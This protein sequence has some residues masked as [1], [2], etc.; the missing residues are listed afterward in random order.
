MKIL[1]KILKVLGILIIL[2]LVAAVVLIKSIK[3][4]GNPQYDGEISLTGLSGEVEVIRDERGVPH[5]YAENEKD[6]YTT[7]GYVMAQERLWQM[8]LIRRATTGRLS[9]I[10]GSDY[11]ETDLFLRSLKM[12]KK[13]EMVLESIDPDIYDALNWFSE[14]V[15]QYIEDAGKNLPTEF[16][17]LRYVPEPWSA[18]YVGNI[19]GYMGWDLA[20]G[21]LSGDIFTHKLIQKIGEDAA[22]QLIPYFDYT[23]DPVYPEF[24]PDMEFLEET[25]AMIKAMDLTADLGLTSFTGS[26]NWAVSGDHSETGLPLFSNDMHLGLSSPGIWMQMHQ[27]IPGKLNVTGVLV[28]GSPFIIAGHNDDIAWGMTNLMVDDIDLYKE[29]VNE[30]GTAYLLDGEWIDIKVEKEVVSTGKENIERE[31][32]YTHRGPIVSGFRNISDAELSMKWVGYDPS[33]E[34]RSVYLLNRASSWDEFNEALTS[35]NAIS[36]NIVYV[37]V[38]GN[39]GLHSAGGIAIR[40]RHGGLIMR[41]DTSLYDWKAYVD[42]YSL[43]YTYNPESGRV[44]SSNNKT[45]TDEYPY[46][47]GTY[48]S[49]PYRINRVRQMLNEKEMFSVEDF[50]RMI[51]DRKSDFAATL[52]PM[53]NVALEDI[54]LAGIDKEVADALS[55]WDYIMSPDIFCPTFFE[56]YYKI[57]TD[58]L[59]EDDMG[60]LYGEF[61]GPVKKYYLLMIMQGEHSLYIDNI[62]TESVEDLESIMISS[63][64]NTIN[65]LS[66]KYGGD[67]SKWIWGDLHAFIAEHPLASVKLIDRLFKLN[68]GPYKVGGSSHTVS[69]YSYSGEF[70]IDHGA[71]ERHIYNPADWDESFTVIPTGISGVPSSE[72]YSSQTE[73]YCNDGFYKDHFSRE[74]VDNAATY[75]LIFK[76]ESK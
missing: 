23:G 6:L 42:H 74:A 69:P 57:L 58:D 75:T 66:G 50:K 24:E 59:L 35:F 11:L 12:D 10:F 27:V 1:K 20:S 67:T 49:M 29:R 63:F 30:D 18:N 68:E 38:N 60:E 36:Q 19:I 47:I 71:S 21:N 62:D 51:T 52:V 53:L 45:V 5:I 26:N 41:G 32:R 4:S 73:T 9:E 76:P 65:T 72:F 31:I 48:F 13:S 22:K 46:Y 61:H 56:Y 44:S 33:D 14:G 28:P 34:V 17:I 7:V 25:T 16:K 40:E 39:I 43:P 70:R 64:Y 2:I 3:E 8:D 54:K 15:N 55:E 37:D